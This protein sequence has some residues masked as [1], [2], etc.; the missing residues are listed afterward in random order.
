MVSQFYDGT[1]ALQEGQ[2][3]PELVETDYGYHIIYRIP[4]NYDITPMK[5]SNYGTYSLRYITALSMFRSNIDTWQA[6]LN[7]TNSD[8]YKSLDFKE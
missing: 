2:F 7:V 6:A 4:V 3:S 1:K 5:Y 8:K